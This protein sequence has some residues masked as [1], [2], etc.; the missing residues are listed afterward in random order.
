MIKAF[1]SRFGIDAFSRAAILLINIL[2]ARRLSVGD[3]G[4]FTY[5]LSL[6]NILYVFTDMGI[7]TFI[8]KEIGASPQKLP[9]AIPHTFTLK[10]AIS[11]ITVGIIIALLPLIWPW[12]YPLLFLAATGWMVGNSF[13]DYYQSF[14]NAIH[15]FSFAAKLLFL[16]RALL[17]VG[18]IILF[19]S[20]SITIANVVITYCVGS[21]T[22]AAL[23]GWMF[24]RRT[25]F[26]FRNISFAGLR[27]IMVSSLPIGI[28]TAMNIAAMRLDTI[29]LALIKGTD[30][31]GIYGA[32]YRLF[33]IAYV[34]SSVLMIVSMPMLA[35]ARD[36]GLDSLKRMLLKLLMIVSLFSLGWITVVMVNAGPIIDLLFGPRYSASIAVLQILAIANVAAF[37]AH[38]ATHALIVMEKQ[39]RHALNQAIT[40]IISVLVNIIFIFQWGATGAAAAALCTQIVI[41]AL[42][43]PVLVRILK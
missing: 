39:N 32:A 21:I 35:R 43:V 11:V 9:W 13:S 16:S 33:E 17:I 38:A 14:C 42:T 24:S 28:A 10:T 19:L 2:I 25:V 8:L 6:A 15:D 26:D 5:A 36:K 3:Y 40:L 34:V 12:K 29:L 31:T 20:N 37:F 22:G 1:L 4:T 41:I 7:H 27:Q 23:A 30:E 18:I